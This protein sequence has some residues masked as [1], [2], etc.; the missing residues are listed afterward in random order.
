MQSK[1]EWWEGLGI[2][3]IVQEF[4]WTTHQCL[5]STLQCIRSGK[6]QKYQ[7]SYNGRSLLLHL[8]CVANVPPSDLWFCGNPTGDLNWEL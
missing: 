4:T 1:T 3:I 5:L 7:V 6:N 2:K 8:F